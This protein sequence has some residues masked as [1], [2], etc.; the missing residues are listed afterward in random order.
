MRGEIEG[1]GMGTR[2]LTGLIHF[3]V[4]QQLTQYCEA[5]LLQ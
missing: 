3:V 4:Q 2:I 1:G 5:L